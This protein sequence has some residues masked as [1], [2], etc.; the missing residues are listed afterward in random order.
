MFRYCNPALTVYD[1]WRL[2]AA[3]AGGEDVLV[4]TRAASARARAADVRSARE[5]Q[6]ALAAEAL[7]ELADESRAASAIRDKYAASAKGG[8]VM[9]GCSS[10]SDRR[11][12]SL[13]ALARP[14]RA[15]VYARLREPAAVRETLPLWRDGAVAWVEEA[16]AP[17]AALEALLDDVLAAAAWL[18]AR[19]GDDDA[20]SAGGEALQA[21]PTEE[22]TWR[23]AERRFNRCILVA[24]LCAAAAAAAPPGVPDASAALAAT[25]PTGSVL[26][27]MRR[28]EAYS[29]PSSVPDA[30]QRQLARSAT[31]ESGRDSSGP[32]Q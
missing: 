2:Q 25:A 12:G 32:L 3:T 18:D 9:R 7:R 11:R 31:F 17:D 26:A 30:A 27:L 19:D 29:A 14:L 21:W 13:H 5:V 15:A 28:F 22:V 16:V 4:P 1:G 24:E 20:D 6:P 23:A 8:A 10:S